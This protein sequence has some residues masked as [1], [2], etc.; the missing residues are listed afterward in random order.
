MG[1]LNILNVSAGDITISFDTKDAAEAIRAKRI[2]EDMLKRGYALLVKD[3]DGAFVRALG[4]DSEKG[5][6]IIA[7]YAPTENNTK[8]TK[9]YEQI[10]E[11]TKEET[12]ST[13]WIKKGAEQP[14]PKRGRQKRVGMETTTTFAVARSAGG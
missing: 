3:S 1:E 8:E 9:N 12:E 14:K 10:E 7:D 5:E 2:I 13:T 6:Y 11:P 4:F